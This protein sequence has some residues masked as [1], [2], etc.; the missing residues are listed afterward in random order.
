MNDGTAAATPTAWR[1]T[2]SRPRAGSPPSPTST[3]PSPATGSTGPPSN[4][5][6]LSRTCG[7]GGGGTSTPTSWTCSS[8]RS[9]RPR[10]RSPTRPADPSEEGSGL[11]QRFARV[12]DAGGSLDRLLHWS[13]GFGDLVRDPG[14]DAGPPVVEPGDQFVRLL[15]H[16]RVRDAPEAGEHRFGEGD[17]PPQLADRPHVFEEGVRDEDDVRR[18]GVGNGGHDP[19]VTGWQDVGQPLGTGGRLVVALL[20]QV[21]DRPFPQGRLEV[22]A[23]GEQ[24]EG[25]PVAQPGGQGA[26]SGDLGIAPGGPVP[27]EAVGQPVEQDVEQRLPLELLQHDDARVA[28]VLQHQCRHEHQGVASTGVPAEDQD[29]APLGRGS[30][31]DDHLDVEQP[32]ADRLETAQPPGHQPV[33]PFLARLAPDPGP[34]PGGQPQPEDHNDAGHLVGAVHDAEGHEPHG[35]PAPGEDVDDGSDDEQ[36]G[37]DDEEEES[38]AGHDRR[39]DDPANKPRRYTDHVSRPLRWKR[40]SECRTLPIPRTP[41]TRVTRYR[42]GTPGSPGTHR[43][44]AARSPRSPSS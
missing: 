44:C 7:P 14:V 8:T 12:G 35:P 11:G 42:R 13:V 41:L 37:G 38:A 4:P 29:R 27:D 32:G 6:T 9:T 21:G 36:D 15:R 39:Q 2:T 10:R 16:H 19:A 26:D 20:A 5:A 40:Y 34:R 43:R 30:V 18:W 1:A 3:T 22:V 31:L 17:P 25:I 33:V 24:H 23:F 28:A